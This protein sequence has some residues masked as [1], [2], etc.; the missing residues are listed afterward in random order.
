M[1]L[2]QGNVRYTP[3]Q[4]VTILGVHIKMPPGREYMYSSETPTKIKKQPRV[5]EDPIAPKQ[6]VEAAK[7]AAGVGVPKIPKPP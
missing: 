6:Q 2:K 5:I 1:R 3:H 4:Y 7:Q